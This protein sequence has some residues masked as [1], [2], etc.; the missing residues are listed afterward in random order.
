[1]TRGA[2]ARRVPARDGMR[3]VVDRGDAARADN[4]TREPHV[5][6]DHVFVALAAGGAP[7][8]A[9]AHQT[10]WFSARAIDHAAGIS[11]D[12]RLQA[13]ELFGRVTGIVGAAL[14]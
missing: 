8:A 5:H 6:L 3:P 2:R 11:E 14:T 9:P 7:A 1:M 13:R 12:S 10:R 4:H